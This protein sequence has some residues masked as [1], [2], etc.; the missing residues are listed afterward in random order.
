[1][2]GMNYFSWR[3]PDPA[4]YKGQ[5][6]I[7]EVSG[8]TCRA[9]PSVSPISD[10]IIRDPKE[11]QCLFPFT[12]DG[13]EEQNT[14][15]LGGIDGFTHPLFKCPVRKIKAGVATTGSGTDYKTSITYP[16]CGAS[17]DNVINFAPVNSELINVGYCPTN[18]ESAT[19][20]WDGTGGVNYTFVDNNPVYGPNGEYELDPENC[21]CAYWQRL[22]VFSV[23]KNNC[24]GGLY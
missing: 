1:M 21:K 7:N 5:G 6:D 15:I 16:S 19:G 17:T 13:G 23:C 24:P 10:V 8:A 22:P 12:V 14:C 4:C 9:N 18:C 2:Y 20:T 3:V 11:A